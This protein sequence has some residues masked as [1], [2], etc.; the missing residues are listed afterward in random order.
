MDVHSV[1]RYV[2]SRRVPCYGCAFRASLRDITYSA[3]LW[4]CIV[5]F[6]TWYVVGQ[7]VE[8]LHYNPEGRGFDS[9]WSH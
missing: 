4:M 9:R 2:I 7:M 1:L 6:A 3:L 5:C 8:E